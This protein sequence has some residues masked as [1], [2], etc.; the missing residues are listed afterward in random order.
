MFH[1][2]APTLAQYAR[3]D[4]DI[5]PL[6]RFA[7]FGAKLVVA[8]AY[9]GLVVALPPRAIAFLALPI[10]VMLLVTL[11]MLPDRGTF[12]RGAI[13]RIFPVFFAFSALWPVYLAVA[14]PGLPWATPTR[15]LLLIMTFLLLY[16]VSISG[17]LRHHLL[18]IAMSSRGM[19]LCFLAWEVMQVVTLPISHA[20][21]WSLKELFDNQFRF[22][23]MLFLGCILFTRPGWATR[24]IGSLI[25]LA[26]VTSL[27]G[28][29]ELHLGAP[30][31][32]NYIPSFMRVDE[33]LLA[34]VLGS[35]ARTADGLYRVRGPFP[36]SLI[37]AEFLALCTPFIVHEIVMGRN[38]VRRI[39]MAAIL[40]LVVTVIFTTQSRLGLVG[41]LLTMIGYPA[42]WAVRQWRL[43]QGGLI[44]PAIVL[45]FPAIAAMMLAVVFSSHTLT[46]RIIG[47]GAQAAST[48]ARAVQRQMA[49]PR[50]LHNPV[51]YGL[52]QSG[53]TLNYTNP[54]GFLTIDSGFI[55]TVLELGVVGF[56]GFYGMCGFAV[57]HGARLF[58]Q[59]SDPEMEL[60]APL[61]LCFAIFVVI[62]YVSTQD[63]NHWLIFLM[64]GMILS[65]VARS[66]GFVGA[67]G[68]VPLGVMPSRGHETP[69]PAAA[70]ASVA[71]VAG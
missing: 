50:I 43:N 56:F 58:I 22:T 54:A 28:L 35:Q 27:D 41:V 37:F 31:W 17:A 53:Q 15:A 1:R 14:L 6:R 51:G 42:L 26:V 23:S 32:A 66:R 67:D 19:W 64:L 71:R 18:A 63:N 39:A 30:P 21:A 59:S 29:V 45:G 8:A 2:P 5:S 47:G 52:G 40:V 68:L 36:N 44:A 16:S 9:G 12:P 20:P 65:F 34:N 38:F 4:V 55:A 13:E 70:A 46:L 62:K 10:V 11:W 60:G 25:L 49:V 33:G 69:I 57:Y 61:S 24:M 7:V 48:E 3:G